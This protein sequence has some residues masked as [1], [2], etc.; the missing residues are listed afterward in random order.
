MNK[1][2]I[3]SIICLSLIMSCLVAS[4]AEKLGGGH[5]GWING[6][7]TRV[8]LLMHPLDADGRTGSFLAALF[9]EDLTKAMVYLVD[10]VL[11][12]GVYY[13][14]PIS[15]TNDGQVTGIDNPDPAL[16]LTITA[17]DNDGSPQFSIT[18]AN[19]SNK[20]GFQENMVFLADHNSD[21][22]WI[23]MRGGRYKSD[24][25]GYYV[26]MPELSSSFS[27]QATVTVNLPQPL[28]GSFLFR[29]KLTDLYTFQRISA[30]STGLE[31]EVQPQKV[32]ISVRWPKWF[33]SDYHM[34]LINP[35]DFTD[36]QI[37]QRK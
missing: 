4:A 25:K 26:D 17:R 10:P 30:L 1:L 23:E 14:H 8:H 28:Q 3:I 33:K 31:K 20:T 27:S 34:L 15:V 11:D 2:K 22:S 13:M 29:Q 5:K 12:A 24:A 35:S 6:T 19:S 7:K 18:S 37:L 21:L 32:A 9:Q 36:V 16:V